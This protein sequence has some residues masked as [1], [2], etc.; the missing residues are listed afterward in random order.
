MQCGTNFAKGCGSEKKFFLRMR[1]ELTP[2]PQI[3]YFM[4]QVALKR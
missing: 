1:F 4:H 3:E 2:K